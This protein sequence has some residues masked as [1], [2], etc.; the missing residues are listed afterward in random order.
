MPNRTQNTTYI[1]AQD[2][3]LEFSSLK[4]AQYEIHQRKMQE[5]MLLFTE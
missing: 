5:N 2:Q 3:L 4:T 1:P